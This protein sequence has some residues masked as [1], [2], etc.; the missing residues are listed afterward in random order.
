MKKRMIVLVMSI[1]M[2]TTQVF[3]QQYKD[4]QRCPKFSWEKN[5][6]EWAKITQDPRWT[7]WAKVLQDPKAI[8]LGK[9]W[10]DYLGYDAVSIINKSKI[11]P[12]IVPGLVINP[13]NYHKYPG[14]KKLLAP[15]FY[16]M[17][18]KGTYGQYGEMLIAPTTHYYN[19]WGRLKFT[20]KYQGTCKIAPDNQTLLNWKAGIPFPFPKTAAEIAHNFDRMTINADQLSF[21]PMHFIMFDRKTKVERVEKFNLFWRNY[22]GRVDV[23]PIPEAP[24][25][26]GEIFEK[27]SLV[28]T[29]PYDLKGYAGVRT[30]F[31]DPAKEDGFEIYLPFL[32]RVRKL[33]GADT[34]DPIIGSDIS[35]EDWKGWWQK[36]SP[37]IWPMEY[38]LVDMNAEFLSGLKWDQ[39]YWMKEVKF[40]N[41]YWSRQPFWVI[42]AIC[43]TKRYLYSRKRLRIE[44]GRFL[45][46]SQIEM[47]DIRGNLWRVW[48][49]ESNLWDPT[50]GYWGWW[51]I[52]C[53]DVY[54]K[55]RTLHYADTILNDPNVTDENFSLGW[56]RKMA[57]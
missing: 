31:T 30:R 34:Q 21:S 44:K 8:A 48:F 55:H 37:K 19:S 1:F 23:P 12:E 39:P 47:Y 57:H 18:Q 43:K 9:A 42:D 38:R 41:N 3:A 5:W 15:P 53:I 16:K 27:G 32:R 6:E 50:M 20:K 54:N 46:M 7:E 14:L 35:W 45:G 40:R 17:L 49:E 33:S 51:G 26:K 13:H 10:A 4:W 36:L 2:V 28:I 56:L 11:A 29:F 22:V 24:E 25:G 52:D